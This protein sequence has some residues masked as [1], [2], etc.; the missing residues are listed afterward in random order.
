MELLT[1]EDGVRV[2]WS[3]LLGWVLLLEREQETRKKGE[4]E[5][6]TKQTDWLSKERGS[7]AW[8]ET[9]AISDSHQ[10][11][12]SLGAGTVSKKGIMLACQ[13]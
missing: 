8:K 10:L 2:E 5:R 11:A 13:T 3:W 12:S 7:E 6:R 4:R 9:M 1:V